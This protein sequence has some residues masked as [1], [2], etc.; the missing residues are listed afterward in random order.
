[1]NSSHSIE[2]APPGELRISIFHVP[3]C[4]SVSRVRQ[5]LEEALDSVGATAVIE[6]I[7][8]AYPSPTVLIDGAEIDGYRL[9]S[10]PACRIGL[11]EAGELAAA[12]V[13]ASARRTHSGRD[14]ADPA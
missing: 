5:T 8:G 14:G 2:G 12:I 4:P 3:D 13:A 10:G 7:E 9:A 11:P 1:V 6:E